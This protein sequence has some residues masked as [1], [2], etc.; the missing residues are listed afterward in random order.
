MPKPS[1]IKNNI[2]KEQKH[3]HIIKEVEVVEANLEMI[4]FDSPL[5]SVAQWRE[6]QNGVLP[7]AREERRT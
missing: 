3:N 6:V 5:W 4:E 2:L 1:C 7:G